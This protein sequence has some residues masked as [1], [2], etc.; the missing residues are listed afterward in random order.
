MKNVLRL[1]AL[2]ASMSLLASAHATIRLFCG[3][4]AVTASSDPRPNSNAAL[5]QFVVI[6]AAQNSMSVADFDGLADRTLSGPVASNMSMASTNVDALN[7]GI[8][9]GDDVIL[10][11]NTTPSI[12]KH[13]RLWS[14]VDTT[15][16]SVTFTFATPVNAFGAFFTGVGTS[17]G[18]TSIKWT[19]SLGTNTLGLGEFPTGSVQFCG[20][21]DSELFTS[22]TIEI[23]PEAGGAIDDVLGVD[24]AFYANCNPVP[25]PGTMAA[26]AVGALALIRKRSRR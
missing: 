18:D 21:I 15:P 10:G 24:D 4:D 16:A 11:F 22:V 19:T 7:G 13:Y 2:A 8:D 25:E 26:L 5:A 17:F 9:S 12:G 1:A 3:L 23:A 6:A 14:D 20:F